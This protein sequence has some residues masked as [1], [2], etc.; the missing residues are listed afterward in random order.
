MV[1]GS[2]SLGTWPPWLGAPARMAQD[3]EHHTHILGNRKGKGIAFKFSSQN[4]HHFC[5]QSNDNIGIGPHLAAKETGKL[6]LILGGHVP[7]KRLDGLLQWERRE[8]PV[9]GEGLPTG[10]AQW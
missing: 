8:K 3:R 6:I 7:A 5:S 10:T 4:E 9:A 1:P 2:F